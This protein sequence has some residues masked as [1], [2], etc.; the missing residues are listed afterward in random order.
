MDTAWDALDL[1]GEAR[2]SWQTIGI[3]TALT[4]KYHQ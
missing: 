1:L 3:W 4:I 2:K